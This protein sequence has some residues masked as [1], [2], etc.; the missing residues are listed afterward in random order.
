MSEH[1][2]R[3]ASEKEKGNKKETH[4]SVVSVALLLSTSATARAPSAPMPLLLRLFARLRGGKMSEPRTPLNRHA[5]AQTHLNSAPQ[6]PSRI[7]WIFRCKSSFESGMAG[8][9]CGENEK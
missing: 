7:D 2:P 4:T 6:V 5:T 1:A 8:G 3:T 9:R